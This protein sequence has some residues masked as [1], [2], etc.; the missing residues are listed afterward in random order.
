MRWDLTEINH[1]GFVF[2]KLQLYRQLEID[3]YVEITWP[4]PESIEFMVRDV[5]AYSRRMI[6]STNNI[7][8]FEG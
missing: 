2:G 1:I 6:N 4:G 3:I 5:R 7:C 8:R